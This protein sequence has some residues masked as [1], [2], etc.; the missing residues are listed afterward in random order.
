MAHPHHT[1]AEVVSTESVIP[2]HAG[3]QLSYDSPAVVY[4]AA[5]EV[6]AGTPVGLPDP[7]NPLN[8]P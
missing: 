3:I 6:R 5:L 7:A 1:F 4:E 2:A 8:I